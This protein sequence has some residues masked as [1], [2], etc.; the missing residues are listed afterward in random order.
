MT[1]KIQDRYELIEWLN[2]GGESIIYKALDHQT[3]K[4]VVL[5]RTRY[6]LPPTIQPQ[7]SRETSLLKGIQHTNVVQLLDCFIHTIEM[8]DYGMMVFEY[9]NGHTLAIEASTKRYTQHEV[10]EIIVEIL[11][12]IVDLQQLTPPILHRDIKPSNILRDIHSGKL[13]LLDFGMATDYHPTEFG[14]TVGVGTLGYQSPEQIYGYPTL[15][16]DVYSVGVIAVELLS[17]RNPKDLLNGHTVDWSGLKGHLS[18]HWTNWLSKV[19]CPV[20]ERYATAEHAI[21]GLSQDLTVNT[22]KKCDTTRHTEPTIIQSTTSHSIKSQSHIPYTV[23]NQRI[24]WMCV[25][26]L[27][28]GMIPIP[29]ILYYHYK[30]RHLSRGIIS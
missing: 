6:G 22:T 2:E 29:F 23:S 20:E 9:V 19:I 4:M 5:K 7:W 26:A 11:A 12:I 27:L 16:S 17:K 10:Q 1:T 15:S 28:L 14:H 21:I 25:G 24:F 13:R 18:Q 30:R 3:S 8:V